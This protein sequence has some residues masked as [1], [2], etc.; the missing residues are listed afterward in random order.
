MKEG[1]IKVIYLLVFV[2]FLIGITIYLIT[3]NANYCGDNLRCSFLKAQQT[4]EA[5]FCNNLDDYSK[6]KCLSYINPELVERT[7]RG[8]NILTNNYIRYPLIAVLITLISMLSYSA[9]FNIKNFISN[10]NFN[11]RK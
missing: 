8:E 6:E 5:R 2:I 11:G 9:F 10:E 3:I 4:Q 7:A 1:V